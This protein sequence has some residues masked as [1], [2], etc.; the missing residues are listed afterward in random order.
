MKDEYEALQQQQSNANVSHAEQTSENFEFGYT[1]QNIQDF[2]T[3]GF[4]ADSGASEHMT[5]K[6]SILINFRPI[7]TG[8]HSVH[9]IGNTCLEAKGRGDVE[10]VN[11]AG[12]TLLLKDVLFVPGLGINLFSISATTSKGEEAIFFKDMVQ[13]T[14]LKKTFFSSF[15]KR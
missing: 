9:G 7:Q 4:V 3:F 14:Y 13:Q 2:E 12:T 5:D 11:A 1:S 10:V 15:I 6:R 8:T